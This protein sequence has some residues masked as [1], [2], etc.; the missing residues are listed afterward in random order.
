[1]D[2]KSAIYMDKIC[3]DTKHIRHIIII[4]NFVR[5]G[6]KCNFHKTLWC[7]GYLQL[8]EIGTKNVREYGLNPALGNAMVRLY[9]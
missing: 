1:M 5:N 3:K 8:S 4:M 9:S 6:K 7:E 2:S